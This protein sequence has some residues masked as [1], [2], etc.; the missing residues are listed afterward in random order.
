[1]AEQQ[2]QRQLQVEAENQTLKG[3]YANN[4]V[5]SH[6]REEFIM[7]FMLI[8][9]PKGL[10]SNRTIVSP[11]H[12]KRMVKAMQDNLKKYEDSFGQIQETTGPEAQEFGFKA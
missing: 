1:M 10:L 7:D 5:I 2:T 8:H 9:P 6:S 12:F 11:G 4:M 3:V